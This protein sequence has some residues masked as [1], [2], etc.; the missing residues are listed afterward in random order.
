MH[1]H[2]R[3]SVIVF[4]LFSFFFSRLPFIRQLT[5]DVRNGITAPP[6]RK[7]RDDL[8]SLTEDKLQSMPRR[9]RK[10]LIFPSSSP[11]IPPFLRG[12]GKFQPG[13]RPIS[14]FPQKVAGSNNWL[15][16]FGTLHIFYS[17][18]SRKKLRFLLKKRRGRW[19]D[20]PSEE[21]RN[22]VCSFEWIFEN[23]WKI[24]ERSKRNLHFRDDIFRSRRLEI[25]KRK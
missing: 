4:S 12:T 2:P 24:S 25:K 16:I 15:T 23:L 18:R 20:D 14:T 9:G 13:E 11:C 17:R 8:D 1:L 6:R 21:D 10:A 3:C 7:R 22:R 5:R 19:I